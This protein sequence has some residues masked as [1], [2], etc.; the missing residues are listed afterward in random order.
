M[1][2]KTFVEQKLEEVERAINMLKNGKTP[3]E[4]T[5][6]AELLKGKGKNLMV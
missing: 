5:I 4:N 1:W 3:R 2:K 6:I